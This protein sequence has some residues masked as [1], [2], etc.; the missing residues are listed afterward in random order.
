[1][2]QEYAE[3]VVRD[4]A[5]HLLQAMVIYGVALTAYWIFVA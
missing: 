4:T 2:D 1:M 3:F 5:L